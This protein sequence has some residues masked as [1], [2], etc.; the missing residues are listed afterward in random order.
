[1]IDSNIPGQKKKKNCTNIETSREMK[2]KRDFQLPR[3]IF[4][5]FFFPP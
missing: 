5:T 2:R 4:D 1:M 3:C